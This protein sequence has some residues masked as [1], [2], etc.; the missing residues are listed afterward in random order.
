MDARIGEI[1]DAQRRSVEETFAILDDIVARHENED[2]DRRLQ[3]EIR[4]IRADTFVLHRRYP[5]AMLE[6]RAIEVDFTC[7]PEAYVANKVAIAR[8]LEKMAMLDEASNE[9]DS[10]LDNPPELHDEALLSIIG[11]RARIAHRAGADVP[12]KYQGLF[13][14]I[15]SRMGIPLKHNEASGSLVDAIREASQLRGEAQNRFMAAYE[16]TQEAPPEVGRQMALEYIATESFGYFREMARAWL[17]P[18]SES[19]GD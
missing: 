12:T 13:D 10:V 17:E 9:L 2:L 4:S 6:L 3:N 5:E 8:V 1:L 16:R 19:S 15:V 18:E 14:G 11:A 7:D